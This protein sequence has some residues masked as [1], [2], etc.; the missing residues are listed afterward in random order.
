MK[1]FAVW[2]VLVLIAG[3]LWA[4]DSLWE[5]GSQGFYTGKIRMKE[6]DLLRVNLDTEASLSFTSSKNSDKLVTFEFT[7]APQGG[8]PLEFLP[9]LKTGDN[10]KLQNKNELKSKNNY[11]MV[12]VKKVNADGTVV[13]EGS[14]SVRFPSGTDTITLSGLIDPRDVKNREVKLAQ[15]A[16][17][18]LFFSTAAESGTNVLSP[19]DFN[20]DGKGLT[21][22]KQKALL[23]S[24]YNRFLDV[25]F[26]AQ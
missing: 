2:T 22:E 7:K 11:I 6:G 18:Q 10:L 20:P 26:P 17:L 23:Q 25:L 1:R 5:P 19:A 24:Y 15:I 9:G 14:R 12:Q 13:V 3:G 21:P 16:N 8:S 4:Q